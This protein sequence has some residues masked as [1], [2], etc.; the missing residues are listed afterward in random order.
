MAGTGSSCQVRR[1]APSSAWRRSGGSRRLRRP[2]NNEDS[3]SGLDSDSAHGRLLL[4]PTQRAH[5]AAAHEPARPRLTTRG[6][7]GP[8]LKSLRRRTAHALRESR[9]THT[10]GPGAAAGTAHAR[11][12]YPAF[13]RLELLGH[14][15]REATVRTRT[16][17]QATLFYV[18]L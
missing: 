18:A 11:G 6:G 12:H 4:W 13:R 3:C 16:E 7:V 10:P 8:G 1:A 2:L 15:G 17:D 9:S 5:Q 14:S